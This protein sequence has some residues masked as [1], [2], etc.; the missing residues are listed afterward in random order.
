MELSKQQASFLDQIKEST[1]HYNE[2]IFWESALT[3]LNNMATEND[4]KWWEFWKSRWSVHHEPLRA[5]A[6]S[7]IQQISD[8]KRKDWVISKV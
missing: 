3:I 1:I 6:K 2:S 7:L 5:D 4:R 8:D